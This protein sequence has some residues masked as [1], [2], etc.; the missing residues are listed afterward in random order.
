[1]IVV[2]GGTGLI[3][4]HLLYQLALEGKKVKALK[5]N[6]S[7]I[8]LVRKVFSY[9]AE[10]ANEL[11]SRIEWANG[12]VLD[13]LSLD[14]AFAGA[15]HVYH[16]AALVSFSPA[17]KKQLLSVN[18]EGTA[19][20]VDACMQAGVKKLCYVSSVAAIG[21]APDGGLCTEDL[22]W[23]PSKN[24]SWYAISKFHAEMEVWRGIEEGLNA[25]I[26]NPSIVLG[27]GNWGQSSTAMFS[28][29]YKG[30]KFYTPGSTGYVD[31]RDVCRAMQL[32]TESNI[33]NQRFILNE[34]NYSFFDIFSQIA[35][36]LGKKPP[37][38]KAQPWMGA[39]AWRAEWLRSKITG[40]QPQITKSSVTSGFKHSQYS[41]QKSLG[42]TGMQYLPIQKS[43]VD[44]STMFLA[45]L[46]KNKVF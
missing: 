33:C 4:S 19:N 9:Y 41:N 24:R 17:L 27:P 18:I 42:I 2:T 15:E 37:T 23:Q 5:R 46:K 1:M 26:V 40:K 22:I 44:F 39:L 34:G 32:L 3:G 20:V 28:S 6:G 8:E 43:I 21:N 10:N 7:N 29:V 31:V 30:L 25:V 36:A 16:T 11:F 45:D 35:L 38:I 13:R 14:E 12:D